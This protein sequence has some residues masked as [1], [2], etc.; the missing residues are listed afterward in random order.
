M[1]EP[2]VISVQFFDRRTKRTPNVSCGV[3]A[4]LVH[5]TDME[6]H[7]RWHRDVGHLEE[8]QVKVFGDSFLVRLCGPLADVHNMGL[9]MEA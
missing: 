8:Y 1:P 6:N 4:A 2:Q 7:A 3:C 5:Q 9:R